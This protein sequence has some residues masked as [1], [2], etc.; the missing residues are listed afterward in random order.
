MINAS[1]LA[2]LLMNFLTIGYW[3]DI[4]TQPANLCSEF[5]NKFWELILKIGSQIFPNLLSKLSSENKYIFL[6]MDNTSDI[7]ISELSKTIMFCEEI[8]VKIT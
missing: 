2:C 5:S 3:I 7:S 4:D 8:W 6:M 1:D